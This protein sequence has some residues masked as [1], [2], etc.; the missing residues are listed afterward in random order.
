ML[1]LWRKIAVVIFAVVIF[2]DMK[3]YDRKT[4]L[5]KL[6]E[7]RRLAFDVHSQLTVVTGRRRIGK[8]KL[9]VKSCD[10]GPTVYLFVSRSNEVAL[11]DDFCGVVR[12]E[13]GVF[14]P[15][16]MRRFAEFFEYLMNLGAT[17]KFNLIIDEFQE[18]ANVNSSIFSEVQNIWDRYKDSTHV[19]FIASGSVYT[20]MHK[21]FMEYDEPL[22]GRCDAVLRIKPF[23]TS[24]LKEILADYNPDYTPDDLLALYAV[25]GGVPKY[26]EYLMDRRAVT[27]KAIFDRV[28]EENS[29]FLE[30]GSILLIQ[31]FGKKYGNYFAILSAIASGCNVVADIANA[32]GENNIG[33]ML[34]RLEDDYGLITKMRPVFAKE[35]SQTVR[36]EIADNFLRF[37]FRYVYRSQSLLQ[38]GKNSEM[39]A[40]AL[41]DYPTYSG[42]VLEKYF[43]AKLAEE[44][45]FREIGSWWQP[46]AGANACEIDIVAIYLSGKKALVA[47]VKRQKRNYDH[48]LFMAKVDRL[49]T[50]ALSPYDIEPRLLTLDD[51]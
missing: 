29:I 1:T 20:L 3:F 50:S 22:Y 24:V 32:V 19:N 39:E 51:M 34:V 13:L 12:S 37:W 46:R 25:T 7:M 44:G 16:G 33:G 35:R 40:I 10:E 26:I 31:E 28:F 21:I 18:F 6:E 5:A 11:C 14:V 43:K 23:A 4:E 17:M 30:E 49:R 45:D 36:Y 47:E 41:V 15:E 27:V 48:K 42:K 8:T 2:D 38:M 9:I